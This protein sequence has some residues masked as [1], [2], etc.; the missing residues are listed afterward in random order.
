M[1]IRY[2]YIVQKVVLIP[3]KRITQRM[4][5]NENIQIFKFKFDNF[6]T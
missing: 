1:A 5:R 4:K 3:L 6:G 2:S